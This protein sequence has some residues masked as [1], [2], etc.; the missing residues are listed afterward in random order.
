MSHSVVIV[1]PAASVDDARL[2]EDADGN[3]AAGFPR[4]LSATG[5]PPP[6]HY[7]CRWTAGAP[8][9]AKY[10]TRQTG[11]VE[12]RPRGGGTWA[13]KSLDAAKVAAVTTAAVVDQR[14]IDEKPGS[15][16]A[17]AE[18]FVSSLGLSFLTETPPGGPLKALSGDREVR[19]L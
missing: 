13:S 8:L 15:A 17:H 18:A 6:T 19:R 11:T 4:G 14:E 3:G 12:Q 5:D 7:C 10:A 16:R 2:M 9:A 1:V